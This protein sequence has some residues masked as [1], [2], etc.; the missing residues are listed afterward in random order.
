MLVA[1]AAAHAGGRRAGRPI[2]H[3][4]GQVGTGCRDIREARPVIAIEPVE[5]VVGHQQVAVAVV[6]EV[7]GQHAET[8]ATISQTEL[9]G[10]LLE[11]P[12]AQV[13]VE[14]VAAVAPV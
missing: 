6:V 3:A 5:P 7:K 8:V 11:A 10:A 14:A 12:V 4:A 1:A 13:A 9:L 2:V